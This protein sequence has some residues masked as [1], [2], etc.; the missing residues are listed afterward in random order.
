MKQAAT[1]VAFALL[2]AGCRGVPTPP[3]ITISGSAVGREA[4]LLREQAARFE[5]LHPEVTVRV[6]P[7]PD[8]AD[9]RHQLFVQWLNA[10]APAPD[11]LQLDVVWT[12]EFA[13]A[14]WIRDLTSLAPELPDF[15]PATI[16]AVRWNERIYAIPWFVDVG[17]LYWRTDLM[18][19]A[20]HTLTELDDQATTAI[21]RRGVPYGLVWQGARYE[22]LVTVFL[23]YLTAFG[24]RILD[25]RGHVVVDSDAATTALTTMRDGIARGN[26]PSSV[27]T[28]QEEQVRFAFQNGQA[29]FMRNWP[30]ASALLSDAATSRVAGRFAVAAMPSGDG[31]ESAAALGGS[32]LAVNAFSARPEAAES[33]VRYLTAPEQMLE[34]ARV[35]GQLP[36]RQRLYS[37]PELKD[38]LPIDP[39]TAR[40]IVARAVPRPVTPVY[41][42]LSE[43]LQIQLHRVLTQQ[44]QP[45]AGLREAAASIRQLLRR[46]GLEGG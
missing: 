25:E 14:G 38:S 10:H 35:L 27:L 11:V 29:A 21:T 19:T 32:E 22:G 5:A 44:A 39:A 17:M 46:A 4:D 31:G 43:I 20:P 40:S 8:S 3:A 33:L 15:F 24:G 9:E 1:C 45:A 34:R 18:A 7:T 16:D 12:A 30:Y 42:E 23:E 6:R 28:W 2:L 36:A 26:V 41:A 37:D 13:A